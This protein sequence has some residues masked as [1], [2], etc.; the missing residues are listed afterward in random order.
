MI[1]TEVKKI[2]VALS[3]LKRCIP[4]KMEKA[5][6]FQC[7]DLLPINSLDELKLFDS[8]I[9][10]GTDFRADYVSCNIFFFNFCNKFFELIFDASLLDG[11]SVDLRR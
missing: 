3:E 1:L 10:T 9:K 6:P 7:K 4:V 11:I 2:K 5:K 8:Y